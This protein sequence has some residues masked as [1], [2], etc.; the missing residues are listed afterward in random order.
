VT[1]LE[2]TISLDPNLLPG[3]VLG[4]ANRARP[5]GESLVWKKFVS[6]AMLADAVHKRLSDDTRTNAMRI[7]VDARAGV[8]R[9]TG[10]VVDVEERDTAAT[11]AQAVPGVRD[12]DNRLEVTRAGAR[13][14]GMSAI[15]ERAQL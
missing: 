9:L 10:D 15:P 2:Q 14:P 6:G 4:P 8:I 7:K 11:V 5:G 1:S 3:I 12:V 13:V